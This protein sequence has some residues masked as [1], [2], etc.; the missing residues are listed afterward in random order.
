M[1]IDKQIEVLLDQRKIRIG[2]CC[3]VYVAVYLAKTKEIARAASDRGCDHLLMLL[4]AE[5]NKDAELKAQADE[6][7]PYPL[8]LATATGI[9]RLLKDS[10]MHIY[11]R[12]ASV[13]I[14]HYS[15]SMANQSAIP[16]FTRRRESG[17]SLS[18]AK[19]HLLKAQP[20]LEF[21]LP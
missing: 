17:L 4:V 20:V 13:V 7:Y 19:E 21:N 15:A 2:D 5:I 6:L 3:G 8:S 1:N 14:D 9:D 10:F 16:G 18:L 12:G 11:A